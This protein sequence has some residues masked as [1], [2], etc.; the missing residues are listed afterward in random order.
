MEVWWIGF[1][2]HPWR[3][4]GYVFVGFCL[5]L[6]YNRFVGLRSDAGWRE[7]MID[8]VEEVGIGIVLAAAVLWGLGQ[9]DATAGG[10]EIVG[11]ITLESMAIAIGVSVG[12]AQLGGDNEDDSGMAADDPLES[13]DE[14]TMFIAQGVIAFCGA[15]LFA[16]N[17]APTEE[18]LLIA[19]ATSDLQL[20]LIAL[21]SIALILITLYYI[22]FIGAHRY[23]RADGLATVVAGAVIMYVIAL[24][25]SALMLWLFGHFDNMSLITGVSKT[26]VLGVA[27]S[28]GASAGR[29]LL[30]S[31]D[32]HG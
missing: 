16:M 32:S 11:K 29:L 14:M 7:V 20:V 10:G 5:L 30:Q 18:I 15:V 12:T 23:V 25:A 28:L 4:F 31:G 26:I 19:I 27:G 1:T 6:G 17:I 22:Q 8:S 13:N 2:A 24:A 9:I 21:A 3:L